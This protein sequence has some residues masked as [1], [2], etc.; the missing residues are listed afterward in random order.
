MR[1]F[2][3]VEFEEGIKEYLYELQ[4]GIKAKSTKGNFTLKD[5]FHLTLHF[6]GQVDIQAID[7][8]KRAINETAQEH[9]NFNISLEGLGQFER[10]NSAIIWV[11]LSKSQALMKLQKDLE[12][13]LSNEGYQ[14]KEKPFRAHVT[15][16]RE[17]ALQQ[18]FKALE[19]IIKRQ[20][21][22]IKVNKVS[23]M[24][25]IRV[26]DKLVYR[27]IYSKELKK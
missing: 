3:A 25:S 27:P 16:G 7:G 5:N 1:V 20:S 22:E 24:E 2:I 9:S 15:L 4:K 13:S 18:D 19:P 26:N 12:D 11:G 14:K 6:I 8:I 10:G 21:K 17:V 23:L